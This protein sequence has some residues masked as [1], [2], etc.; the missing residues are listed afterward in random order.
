MNAQIAT[1]PDPYSVALDTVDLTDPALYQNNHHWGFF[2]R[3]REEDP[4]HHNSVGR[5]GPFWSITRYQDIVE[6]C[7]NSKVFSSHNTTILED[8]MAAG[9]TDSTDEDFAKIGFVAMDDPEHAIRRKMV[10]PAFAAQNLADMEDMIRQ[11]T[12]KV[13]SDLPIGEEFEW[14][15]TVS[16]TLTGLMLSTLLGF[17]PEDRHKVR[18]WSDL[19]ASAA[20]DGAYDSYEERDIELQEMVRY[21]IDLREMTRNGTIKDGLISMMINSPA[22]KDVPPGQYVSDMSLLIV[23]GTDTTRN[24]MSG[25]IAAFHDFPAEWAK[26]REN[27][28]LLASAVPEMVRWQTPFIHV[29]RRALE[30]YEIGGKTIRKGDKVAIWGIS[31]NRDET[32]IEN[33]DQFIIDRTNARQH[34]SFGFGIHRCIGN[35]LAEMQIRILWEEIL[36]MG[37]SRI[38]VVGGPFYTRNNQVRSIGSL[39]TRIHA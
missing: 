4:V 26:L 13:L 14:V 38:E 9:G 30:D 1:A 2:K 37:W 29:G 17:P 36:K 6:I 32:A 11:R 24:T 27:P 10:A 33:A 16:A 34:L 31:G 8:A 25:S 23:G 22:S 15:E 20:G 7:N 18:R 21:F 5:F 39:I 28:A 12:R 19:L 35:R 3:L